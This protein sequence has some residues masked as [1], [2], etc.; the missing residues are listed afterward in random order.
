[1]AQCSSPILAGRVPGV[2]KL[3]IFP[4][5]ADQG[6]NDYVGKYG[7]ENLFF[8]PCGKCPACI[9][10]RKKAWSIRCCMEAQTHQENC[11]VTL[12]YDD[13][14]YPGKMVRDDLLGF[15]KNLR[16]DG[17]KVRYFG[18]GEHGSQGGRCHF[19][20]ILF[21][22]MPSDMKYYA[23][24]KS[25]IPTYSSRIIDNAWRYK[26]MAL[27]QEFSPFAASYVAG[28]VLKKMFDKDDSFHI[29]STRPGIGA[30][31]FL[32]HIE[33]IYDTDNLILN[34]GS[35][36]FS[37]PRYFDKLADSLDLDL[38]DIKAKRL[39]KS[40]A[41]SYKDMREK[42]YRCLEEYYW[43]E[44]QKYEKNLALKERVL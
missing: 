2:K 23:K 41:L 17:I 26:G 15:I 33:D 22:W 19:H 6:F 40:Y 37:V 34:F 3:R 11:F 25:G 31:Y 44:S 21:G 36:V 32:Q 5:R 24:S 12:T 10:R 18:C 8:L 43:Q 9:S 30:A 20:I 1:M 29:Q 27:V 7:R 28:Y 42:G 38:T 4:I 16:N 35:H 39:D 13:D 14:H